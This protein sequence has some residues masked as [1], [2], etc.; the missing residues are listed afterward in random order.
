MAHMP[1]TIARAH[2]QRGSD[3]DPARPRPAR[4]SL[5]ICGLMII[6][7]LLAHRLHLGLGSTTFL[8]IG[9]AC[10]AAGALVK[11]WAC[12][13]ALAG[14]V[15]ALAA[16]WYTLR[17]HERVD[18]DLAS[19]IQQAAE[20]QEGGAVIITTIRGV[21]RDVP[22]RVAFADGALERFG[23]GAPTS[24]FEL[25]I[26]QIGSFSGT[27]TVRVRVEC[28][29]RS[30]PEIVRPGA[31]L[32]ISGRVRPV[33][34]EMNP[35]EPDWRSL[36]VQDGVIGSLDV[37]ETAL[38]IADR[39]AD[40]RERIL[41]TWHGAVGGLR[42]RCLDVLERGPDD[43]PPTPS[44]ALLGALL[45]GERDRALDEV[46]DAFTR[47]GLVHLV[48]ISGFNLAVMAGLVLMLLRL[49]G[50]RGWLEPVIVAVLVVAYML[51]LPAQAPILRAGTIVLVLLIAD[52]LGRRYDRATLLGWVACAMLVV[53]PLDAWSM[54]FQLSFGIVAALLVLG[55]TMHQR[56]WGVPI[57][58]LAV[59]VPK[60]GPWVIAWIPPALRWVIEAFKV[61]ISAAILAWGVSL[62]I[63][64][65]G[66]GQLSL[67]APLTTLVVLP[68]TVVVLWA[69]YIVLLV[70]VA[71]PAMGSIASGA[72]DACAGVL[73]EVVMRLDALG[74]GFVQ[75]PPLSPIWAVAS[76]ATIVVA[77]ARLHLRDA[78]LW[79]SGAILIAWL[80]VQI[81]L[82]PR[83]P[84]NTLLRVDTLSVGQGSCHLLRSGG[85]AML[86][87]CG[88]TDTS[89]GVRRVPQACRNLGVRGVKTILITGPTLDR[90]SGVVDVLG[91][92]GVQTVMVPA[93]LVQAAALYPDGP[94]GLMLS[95]V[96]ARGVSVQEL[97]PGDELRFGRVTIGILPAGPSEIA[98]RVVSS[99]LLGTPRSALFLGDLAEA[100]IAPMHKAIGERA[101]MI[102]ITGRGAA[103][104][105]SAQF[106]RGLA[107]A[108]IVHSS[109][110]RSA[111]AARWRERVPAAVT[112]STGVHGWTWTEFLDDGRIA[113]RSMWS[114]K[115]G[116]EA[117]R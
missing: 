40:V 75:G 53:R 47:L 81:V 73:V 61:Q 96:R 76:A 93:E 105:A 46:N 3:A 28:D 32:S 24:A 18:G 88:S 29:L 92:M 37:P 94:A 101:E 100:S 11:G 19:A 7:F 5:F 90:L 50:D 6:G 82:L 99:D 20:A 34:R 51:V 67:L 16:G 55:D 114:E 70:G 112:R 108:V 86:V 54:G 52:A 71:I 60:R 65:A 78:R 4:R 59:R 110:A 89:V 57:R 113:T 77:M 41:S 62:P 115:C 56:L 69:G 38:I 84:A 2:G 15:V 85:E 8:A 9:A 26:S 44:R 111:H 13:A 117:R 49:T 42:M 58:G 72:L 102:A 95:L 1:W 91:P 22:R 27:G 36:A 43:G 17:I 45:L 33:G 39:P 64:A 87:D 48:A 63:I 25:A 66:T 31:V 97:R 109:A 14:G 68:I 80:G 21:V 30:L 79:V 23:R 83:A 103:D 10:C 35:G 104:D 12:K 98:V 107:P 74:A 106:V 116:D